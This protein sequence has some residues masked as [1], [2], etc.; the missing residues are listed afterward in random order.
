MD[1]NKQQFYIPAPNGQGELIIPASKM[2]VVD[3]S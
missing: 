2:L 3:L 1:F